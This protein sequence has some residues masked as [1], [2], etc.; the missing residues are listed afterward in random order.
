VYLKERLQTY[1]IERYFPKSISTSSIS[2]NVFPETLALYFSRESK[3]E[4][5]DSDPKIPT[6]LRMTINRL[7]SKKVFSLK[8]PT[9]FSPQFLKEKHLL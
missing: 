7:S 1:Y 5:I 4:D 8:L 9:T 3:K 2:R 6:F